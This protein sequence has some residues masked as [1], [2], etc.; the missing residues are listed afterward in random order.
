MEVWSLNL[1]HLRA[2]LETARLG[3]I[4]AAAQAINLTQPAITQALSNLEA[5]LELQLFERRHDGMVPQDAMNLLM[6]R[7]EAA[8]THVG[9]VRVTMAQMRALI[10]LG[11]EGSYS[12]ASKATRLAQPSLHR[13]VNDLSVSLRRTLVERRG[14]G[15]GLTE[16][17]RHT[18]R[19]FRLARAE[20]VAGLSEI[21]GLMGR[22]TGR[23]AIGAMPL[24]RARV[25]PA[26][27][28]AFH[29][30][31]PDVLI[32]L[33]EGSWLELVEP[34]RDGEIDMMVGALREP[35]DDLVQYALFKDLPVIIGRKGH[36]AIDVGTA[37]PSLA[38][39]TWIVPPPGTPLR[40]QWQAMFEES[41]IVPPNVPI[42]C[43]SVM[44]I[45]QILIES[46]FLTL[47]SPDQVAVELEAGWLEVIC[48][49]PPGISRTI[50]VTT[51][52]GW[53]PTA[54]QQAFLDH[55]STIASSKLQENL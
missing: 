52:A 51:R 26:A 2:A 40:A 35:I 43:G 3:S 49:A 22:E 38:E 6:P 36:P 15:V 30:A 20:L 32:S 39:F 55:L 13:A 37:L 10:A 24:S 28:A 33:L 48:D 31:H 50:G 19:G 45:R 17:G 44:M 46:D 23:L 5:Q 47:L 54:K 27:I 21:E 18:L 8:L 29:P 41:G 14:K 16:S 42:E 25:L 53:Q 12:Q 1:R 9:S 7:I 11:D 4:S 34:L